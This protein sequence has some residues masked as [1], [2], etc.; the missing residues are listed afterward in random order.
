MAKKPV[1]PDATK[2]TPHDAGNGRLVSDS[3][4][5]KATPVDGLYENWFLDYASY[6]ILDRAVPYVEDGLKPVQRRILHAMDELD[7]GRFNKVA[8][9]IGH[10]MQYHP[11]GDASIGDAIVNLGQRNLLIETQGNWGN[12][13]TG[14]SAAAPRYIEARLSKFGREILFNPKTTAWQLSYDGRK[15]EPVTLP[16]KFPLLLA[17][18]AEGIAVGLSTKI[19]PHNFCELCECSILALKKQPFTLYPDFPTGGLVD[20]T[21]Y[22]GG[23]RGGRVRVRA[24]IKEMDKKTLSITELPFG[25]TTGSL[26]ESIIKASEK[27]KIKIRQIEDNTARNVEILVHL[28]PGASTDITID[29]L[30]AFTDCETALSPNCCI[31]LKE[32]PLFTTVE[33]VLR[34]AAEATKQLLKREL[35]IRL[36]ELEEEWHFSSLEKIFIEKKIY[37]DIEEATTWEMVLGNIDKGLKPYKKLFRR[38]I[39]QDDI[40]KLTEIRIKRISKFDAFKADEHIRGLEAEMDE[41][42]NN[43]AHITD[44]TVRYYR[45]LLKKY[46]AG[47]ERKTEIKTF[48]TIQA[49]IVAAA[50][51]KLYVNRAEGFIGWGLKKDE[52]VADCSDIDDIIVF[53]KDGVMQVVRI[54]EK[55]YVGKNVEYVGVFRKDDDRAVYHMVYQDGKMGKVYAKRFQ[56]QGVTRNKEYN[57]T[58]GGKESQL[59]YISAMPNGES[60]VVTVHHKNIPRIRRLEFQFDFGNMVI[61]GRGAGGNILTKWPVRKVARK[62]VGASTL[63]SRPIWYDPGIMRLNAD[64]NGFYLGR[65]DAD[66]KILVLYDDGTYELTSFE[67]TN[68]YE[69]K[70]TVMDMVKFVPD[71]VV[72]AIYYDA[73]DKVYYAKRFLIETTTPDKKFPFIG[74]EGGNKLAFATARMAPV[75]QLTVVDKKNKP[76]EGKEIELEDFVDVKGWKAVG[77]RITSE[78]VQSVKLVRYEPDPALSTDND[79]DADEAEEADEAPAPKAAPKT[80]PKA[81]AQPKPAKAP[82]KG[83][84][85]GAKGKTLF[86]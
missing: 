68:R 21:D 49:N 2:T 81:K 12:I 4:M 29:A 22:K 74:E 77:K 23:E 75:V 71:V 19:L 69:G 17:Q 39:T 53:R 82:T 14:D 44:Y 25:S 66:D 52:F 8:N 72:S 84:K 42:K 30:Y 76:Y 24:R 51:T 67:L 78:T 65:F 62:S 41:V 15:K 85:P 46:G 47:R 57:L 80:S 56:V 55:V 38:E 28:A 59:L 10:T 50:N 58:K 36:Q 32:K 35:E 18:G 7:D 54:G 63:A 16:V 20:V 83:K 9:I 34:R 3:E 37:R 13:H 11:H 26:I 45:D 27:G 6:V 61:K 33:D 64:G 86:D 43:L 40:V 73:K 79:A 31:I 60:E 5:H 70:G 48:D 1:K